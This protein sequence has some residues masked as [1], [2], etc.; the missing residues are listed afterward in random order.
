MLKNDGK[1]I[2]YENKAQSSGNLLKVVPSNHTI[3]AMMSVTV[4]SPPDFP[5]NARIFGIELQTF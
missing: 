1:I 5:A 3:D 2:I 4:A